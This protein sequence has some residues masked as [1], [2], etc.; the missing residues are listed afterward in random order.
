MNQK[1]TIF[2][3]IF[4]IVLFFILTIVSAKN[5]SKIMYL[6]GGNGK[7][8]VI[9]QNTTY[10]NGKSNN[11][12]SVNKGKKE[13]NK[14]SEYGQKENGN[15]IQQYKNINYFLIAI[16]CLSIAMSITL[17][18]T[19]FILIYLIKNRKIAKN[20]SLENEN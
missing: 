19:L 20:I 15:N 7:N 14:K 10:K 3:T 6:T 8:T 11:S 12:K 5:H 2:T 9:S 17:F 4:F 1:I 18:L 13:E 16:I